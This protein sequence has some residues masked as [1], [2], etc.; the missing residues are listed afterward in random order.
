[1]HHDASYVFLILAMLIL[2][3]GTFSPWFFY[4]RENRPYY[5]SFVCAGLFCFILSI[6]LKA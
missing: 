1:M 6:F 5:P 3:I 2:G 4:A